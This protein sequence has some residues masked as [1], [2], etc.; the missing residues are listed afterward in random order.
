MEKNKNKNTYSAN[1][2]RGNTDEEEFGYA[3]TAE[4]DR[5]DFL[6]KISTKQNAFLEI[7]EREGVG[8]RVELEEEEVTIGRVPECK[9]QLLVENVSRRHARILYRNEEYCIED[10]ESKNGVYVNGIRVEKCVLRR[11]DVIEIGGVKI[12]FVEE[13]TRR[14][15]EC[16]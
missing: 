12:L 8:K 10:L 11:H 3:R 9:I 15:Y 16:E 14:D 2:E 6:E 5:E 7:I 1:P 4:I 13:E